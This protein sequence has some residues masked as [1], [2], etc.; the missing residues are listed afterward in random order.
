MKQDGIIDAH[1]HVFRPASVYQRNVDQL[2]PADRDAPVEDLLAHM[3]GG[4]VAAA[5]LVPL[6]AQTTMPPGAR[7]VPETFGGVA[8]GA[9]TEVRTG[10]HP[11]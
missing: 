11:R 7:P 2:A 8:V 6:D 5:V 10:R 4:G 1:S 9:P 3:A